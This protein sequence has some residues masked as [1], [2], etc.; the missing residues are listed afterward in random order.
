MCA[1]RLRHDDETASLEGSVD[2]RDGGSEPGPTRRAWGGW[3]EANDEFA[4]SEGDEGKFFNLL[5]LREQLL[6]LLNFIIRNF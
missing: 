3:E 2:I 5:C 6:T 4:V 1:L